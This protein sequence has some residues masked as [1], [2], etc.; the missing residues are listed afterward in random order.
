MTGWLS[1]ASMAVAVVC[2]LATAD[3]KFVVAWLI[4]LCS[5]MSEARLWAISASS[6]RTLGFFFHHQL[7]CGL[8]ARGAFASSRVP[9]AVG[10]LR[11]VSSD[12]KIVAASPGCPS[13]GSP[14]RDGFRG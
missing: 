12:R 5:E 13:A 1:F 7:I 4:V 3:C 6:S 8:Y 11:G 10:T 9:R 2:R 14:A